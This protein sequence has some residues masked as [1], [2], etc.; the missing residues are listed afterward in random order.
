MS[1]WDMATEAME[2]AVVKVVHYF[3]GAGDTEAVENSALSSK[4]EPHS[5]LSASLRTWAT[6]SE[7]TDYYPTRA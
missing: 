4:P 7:R 3:D 6:A 2:A 5:P 1:F